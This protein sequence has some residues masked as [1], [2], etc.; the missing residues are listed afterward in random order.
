M[1]VS[2][3]RGLGDTGLRRVFL[4]VLN[5]RA[6]YCIMPDLWGFVPGMSDGGCFLFFCQ[7]LI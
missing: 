4:V 3:N 7:S 1:V 2:Y 6:N 5:E